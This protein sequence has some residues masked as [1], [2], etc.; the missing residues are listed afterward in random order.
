MNIA[1]IG[2]G[3][4]GRTLALT[5]E[6]AFANTTTKTR[7][8][9]VGCAITLFE[10][11]T[12]TDS[13]QTAMIAAAMIAPVAESTHSPLQIV[14]L[15][16]QGLS[17][18]P[19]MLEYLNLNPSHFHSLG[20][21]VVAFRQDKNEL[22]QFLNLIPQ[23]L[24]NNVHQLSQSDIFAKEPELNQ[25]INHGYFIESEG[26]VD[27]VALLNEM[28]QKL[29][30]SSVIVKENSPESPETLKQ[31]D[32]K[33][34]FDIIIDCRG[35]GAK[36]S[37]TL[38]K[39]RGVRG[40]VIRVHAPEVSLRRP[41]RLMHPR[42]SLYIVPK[43]NHR[44]VIGATEIESEATTPITV[45]SALELLSAAYSVHRGF[46]EAQIEQTSVG[47]RPT[48]P[49]HLPAIVQS[50]NVIQINGL[51]RHG[52]MLLPS[53]INKAW[54]ILMKQLS[55]DLAVPFINEELLMEEI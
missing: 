47:L 14:K 43:P 5:L 2:A 34:P 19:S 28:T 1:I 9:Q 20:S 3:L 12:I 38:N 39:L 27:N 26:H 11:G 15:G 13:Q 10:K 35:I 54:P 6:Q 53:I 36:G 31:K 21:L 24:K 42:Y 55:T 51:Y 37:K 40:E 32:A 44:F 52:F 8:Q 18:W 23:T 4:L 48:M 29:K 17:L 46:A 25:Q 45:R 7:S 41:I 22:Q 33:V 30:T 49:D 16:Q 50:D